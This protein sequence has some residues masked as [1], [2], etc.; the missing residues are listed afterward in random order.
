[1]VAVRNPSPT[2]SVVAAVMIRCRVSRDCSAFD[3]R[4]FV[5]EPDATLDHL[6]SCS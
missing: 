6:S 5:R 2:N 4:F 1:M 3:T